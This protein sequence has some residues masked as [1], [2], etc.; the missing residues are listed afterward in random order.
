MSDTNEERGLSFRRCDVHHL[1]DPFA[2][3]R[4]PFQPDGQCGRRQADDEGLLDLTR[5]E[6]DVALD[7]NPAGRREDFFHEGGCHALAGSRS[8]S[9]EESNG[10]RA[11]RAESAPVGAG[12]PW[13]GLH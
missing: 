11:S 7:G 12:M 8:S 4:V 6:F 2:G 5:V 9:A 3:R 10:K 1:A 13:S